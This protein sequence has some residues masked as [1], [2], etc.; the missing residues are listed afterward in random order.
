MTAD[1]RFA[2]TACGRCCTGWLPLTLGD[3][4][5]HAGRFPLAVVWTP[6]RQ[7]NAEFQAAS[8]FGLTVRLPNRKTVAVRLMPT[9]YQPKSFPCPELTP[10][11]LCGIHADKPARCR[12]MPFFPYREEV[13]QADLLIPRAGWACDTSEAAPVVYSGGRIVDRTDFDD[14]VASLK[15]DAMLLR[16]H[17]EVCLAANRDVLP[18][19]ARAAGDGRGGG[20]LVTGF[21]ALLPRLKSS[22]VADFV[23]A[24]V[25]VLQRYAALTQDDP[26]H[27]T[28]H[29][30]YM[31][32]LAELKPVLA[33]TE[34]G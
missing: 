23:R 9:A 3:A 5:R 30:N 22:I 19:L 29:R 28:Y 11:G 12:T 20:H 10:A 18:A 26:E 14:E 7:G 15:K 16:M 21:A 31:D 17:A 1:R 4:L 27:R 8:R 33:A 24:Q 2:C 25:P 13:D 32:W 34:A 6:I